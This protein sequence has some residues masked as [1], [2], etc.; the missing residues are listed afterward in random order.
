MRGS[1]LIK[2]GLMFAIFGIPAAQAQ[3]RPA[4]KQL[5]VPR[6]DVSVGYNNIRANAPPASCD[7]FEMNGGYVSANMHLTD[8]FG[9]AGEFT[10]NRASDVSVLGQDLTLTTF[11][12]GPRATF[13]LRRFT[14]FGEALIGGAHGSD[15]YF[16]SKTSSSTSASSF[17]FSTGGGLDYR[18]TPRFSIRAI[19][20]QFLRTSFPNGTDNTQNHLMIGAGLVVKFGGFSKREPRAVL[21]PQVAPA[22]TQPPPPT[23]AFTCG[24]NVANVPV[25]QMIQIFGNARTEPEK[26]DVV[27]TWSAQGAK[28]DGSGSTVSINTTALA[29]GDYRVQGRASLASNPSITAECN[30]VFRVIA[31]EQPPAPSTTYVTIADPAAKDEKLF[32]ENVKDAFFDVNSSAIRPDTQASINRAASYLIAHPTIHVL[33]SGWADPRGSVQF[34]LALGIRRAAAVRSALIAANVPESQL[35]VISNGKSSQVCTTSDK[36]CWQ[37]NRRVSFTMKP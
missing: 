33:I 18:L 35:E 20:L 5:D 24:T 21:P 37:K 22:P 30:A 29:V 6:F 23:V 34:N 17:A 7:C 3:A 2:I 28:V 9:V 25:G 4:V 10:G 16:P 12:I 15:S 13:R 14:T 27:Y 1:S 8:W 32:H 19:D 26:L 11:T 36:S 31:V